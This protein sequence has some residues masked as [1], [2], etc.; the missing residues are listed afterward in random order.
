LKF[1]DRIISDLQGR[2]GRFF[3]TPATSPNDL[4]KPTSKIV[5]SG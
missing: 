1:D 3:A 5:V 4:S 2:N